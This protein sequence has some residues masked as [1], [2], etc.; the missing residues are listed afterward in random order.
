M[1]DHP[2]DNLHVRNLFGHRILLL[3]DRA[4]DDID[5]I[6]MLGREQCA[7]LEAPTLR[8]WSGALMRSAL[9]NFAWILE[10]FGCFS[11]ASSVVLVLSVMFPASFIRLVA[12]IRPRARAI[13]YPYPSNMSLTKSKSSSRLLFDV[14][15]VEGQHVLKQASAE[16]C[17]GRVVSAQSFGLPRTPR[18]VVVRLGG[19]ARLLSTRALRTAGVRDHRPSVR[20]PDPEGELARMRPQQS[21][22]IY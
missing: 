1:H 8:C 17:W 6:R 13:P 9:N 14:D 5:R 3:S 7:F 2:A 16:H 12:L 11:R 10:R 18:N 22:K 20:A 4:L 15:V 21:E 19:H